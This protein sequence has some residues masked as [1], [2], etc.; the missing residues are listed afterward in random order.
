[1]S[2]P[3]ADVRELFEQATKRLLDRMDGLTDDEWAWR[4]VP[5][6]DELTIRWR[7]DHIADA[8]G[9][10]RNWQW[11]GASD[12]PELVPA[13]S[14][15][16]AIATVRDVVDRFIALTNR[17]EIDLDQ[18]IGPIGGFY[19]EHPRRALVLHTVDELIHHAA[20]AAL[21]RDLYSAG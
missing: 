14:A 18:P 2:Y 13:D 20:E 11:L 3:R 12:A 6:D 4:P 16:M 15:A 8:V 19:A 10:Q 1:M 17:P 5:E 7:L 9:G 21:L